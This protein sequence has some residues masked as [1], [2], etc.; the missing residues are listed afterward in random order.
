MTN[1]D[2]EISIDSSLRPQKNPVTLSAVH[3]KPNEDTTVD[4]MQCNKA[5]IHGVD[6]FIEGSP[7]I[8]SKPRTALF[9]EGEE[10]EPWLIKIFLL[11]FHRA[12]ARI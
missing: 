4:S 6:Q 3:V 5:T 11:V 7:K 2:S 10:D 9:K 1:Y 12:D 8:I